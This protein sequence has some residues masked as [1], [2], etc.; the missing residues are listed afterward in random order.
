MMLRIFISILLLSRVFTPSVVYSVDSMPYNQNTMSNVTVVK[1]EEKKGDVKYTVTEKVNINDFSAPLCS[2]VPLVFTNCI[3]SI[4]IEKTPFG[5]LYKEIKGANKEKGTCHYQERTRGFGGLDCNFQNSVLAKVEALYTKK[6]LSVVDVS[7]K[8]NSQ[9]ID[10]LR[11]INEESCVAVGDLELQSALQLDTSTVSKTPDLKKVEEKAVE[12]PTP[13]EEVAK[14]DAPKADVKEDV[15]SET[16]Q[17]NQYKSVMFTDQELSLI[18][19]SVRAFKAGTGLA[20]A[21]LAQGVENQIRSYH[22]NSIIYKGENQWTIWLNNNKLSPGSDAGGLKIESVSEHSATVKWFTS[23]L[24]RITPDWR[25]KLVIV[26]NNKYKAKPSD[27]AIVIEV[28]D[29]NSV[30]I[31]FRLE[32]NQ[33]FDVNNMKIKEGNS[34]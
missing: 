19:E 27:G 30:L 1:E 16:G 5:V 33:T 32:P 9:E 34:G 20:A 7:K 11:V 8:L 12:M 18:S 24:D 29:Q 23:E 28:Q 2:D 3:P 21:G 26:S 15:F 25:R 4:C 17:D 22:L 14:K 13:Q 31:T 10:N 6:S